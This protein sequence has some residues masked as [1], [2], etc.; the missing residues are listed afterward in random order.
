MDETF[1]D[2]VLLDAR[3][4]GMS[5]AEACKQLVAPRPEVAV[6]MVSTYSDPLLVEEC[7]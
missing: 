3:L 5:G 6:L 4:P 7:I 2:V 1:P